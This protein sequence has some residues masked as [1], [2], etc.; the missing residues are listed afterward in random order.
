MQMHSIPALCSMKSIQCPSLRSSTALWNTRRYYS[1]RPSK[2]EPHHIA[3]IGGGITGLA[4]TFYA[5]KRFPRAKITLF[6][7]SNRLGGVIDSITVQLKD[8]TSAVCEMGP[9]T[10]RANAPRAIV[11]IDLVSMQRRQSSHKEPS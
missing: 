8:G 9:R 11:T 1:T 6:E 7:A 2:T 10:L 3:V 5:A 4:T